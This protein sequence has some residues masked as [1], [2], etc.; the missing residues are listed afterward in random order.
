MATRCSSCLA[1]ILALCEPLVKHWVCTRRWL[2]PANQCCDVAYSTAFLPACQSPMPYG[3]TLGCFA[4][5]LHLGPWP[6]ELVCSALAWGCFPSIWLRTLQ[7]CSHPVK[8][9]FILAVLVLPLG[10]GWD[11]NWSGPLCILSGERACCVPARSAP[12]EVAT[13]RLVIL[14]PI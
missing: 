5:G 3:L 1:A 6:L 14:I 9:C 7:R 11:S 2:L 13:R 8:L 12:C 10:V 4:L